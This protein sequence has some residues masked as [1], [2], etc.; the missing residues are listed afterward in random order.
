[1][2]LFW[3]TILSAVQP[4]CAAARIPYATATF[5]PVASPVLSPRAEKLHTVARRAISRGRLDDALQMY[6]SAAAD[7]GAGHASLLLALHLRRM[8]ESADRV[9]AAFSEG[10][11][12]D[13]GY[14]RLLQAWGLFE[15]KHGKPATALALVEHAVRLDPSLGAIL[16][17]ERFATIRNQAASRRRPPV[18][19]LGVAAPAARQRV[20]IF[21]RHVSTAAIHEVGNTLHA[22]TMGDSSGGVATAG[23]GGGGGGRGGPSPSS[24]SS[25]SSSPPSGVLR[26]RE[27]P[28]VYQVPQSKR[29]WRGR[30]ELGEDPALWYD[31]EGVRRGPPQNYWRQAMDERLHGED[32]EALEALLEECAAEG[33]PR[34]AGEGEDPSTLDALGR[35]MRV[36]RPGLNRKLLGE[37]AP[38]VLRGRRALAKEGSVP[39]LLRVRRSG[40]PRLEVHTYGER[41][42]HLEEGEP[43]ALETERGEGGGARVDAAATADAFA[44]A[45]GGGLE[46]C[47]GSAVV[48]LSDYLLIVQRS[49]EEGGAVDV[50]LRQL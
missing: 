35:R 11:K 8:G 19:S 43:L 2:M 5:T 40:G 25:A 23:G 1:M 41:E 46:V 33:G 15:S 10:V 31:D 24:P 7:C 18:M 45:E 37:W 21:Q 48:Y 16:R 32:M 36:R 9:R 28:V 14:A 17:W 30:A 26:A 22:E 4:G 20:R 29:G 50:W 27:P 6:R 49:E 39:F 47:E 42:M 38:A 34:R 44:C 13:R 3:P 12:R